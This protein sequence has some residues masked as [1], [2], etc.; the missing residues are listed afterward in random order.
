MTQTLFS[1]EAISTQRK[2]FIE[3]CFQRLSKQF[4]VP[5]PKYFIETDWQREPQV[6]GFFSPAGNF[7]VLNGKFVNENIALTLR[8]VKHEFA[9]YLIQTKLLEIP[10][11]IDFIGGRLQEKVCYRFEKDYRA[12]KIQPTSQTNLLS[13][14]MSDAKKCE[15][16][17]RKIARGLPL[18]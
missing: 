2:D 16:L 10:H 1:K 12:L 18:P 14:N 11:F 5:M 3:K 13:V 17:D 15:T 8:T 6:A 9:H 4:D 7:I